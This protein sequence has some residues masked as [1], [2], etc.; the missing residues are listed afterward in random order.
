LQK[1]I[2]RSYKLHRSYKTYVFV[3]LLF[4][5]APACP[6]FGAE[7]SGTY[8]ALFQNRENAAGNKESVLDNYLMLDATNIGRPDISAHVYGKYGRDL[9]DDFSDSSIYYG[10]LQYKTFQ[11]ATDIKLGRF[12]METHRFLTVDGLSAYFRPAG[13]VGF[14]AFGGVPKY[15]DIDPDRFNRQFSETGGLIF[16][17]RVFLQG[18]ENTRAYAGYSREWK[19][20]DAYRELLSAGGGRDISGNVLGNELKVSLDAS[21]DYNEASSGMEK[22]TARLFAT[23]ARKLTLIVE[24]D[25]YDVKNEYPEGR[26]LVL[27]MLSDGREDRVFY[28]LSYN[29]TK[30]VSVYQSSVFTYLRMPD[31]EWQRGTILKGGFGADYVRELGLDVDVSVY[32]F[33]SFIAN[34]SGISARIKGRP[35]R[36]WIVE[37]GVEAVHFDTPFRNDKFA[38]T[39]T[40]EI[41]YQPK[42]KYKVA[43]FVERSDNPEYRSDF[44]TGVKFDYN[45]SFSGGKGGQIR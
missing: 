15:L 45:F 42:P 8:S 3:I 33:E 36:S 13:L 32:R 27:S 43:L 4:I 25:R 9:N 34:A 23:Y 26:E 6:L 39:V 18:I 29:I 31:G 41:G 16:G 7:V 35:F 28:T 2:N 21:A 12:P 1:K 5:L 14:T 40:G 20:S 30:R 37:S 44:R 17:G 24:A 10:Y 38:R 22:A 19:G 11:G